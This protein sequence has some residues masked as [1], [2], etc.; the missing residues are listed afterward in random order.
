MIKKIICLVLLLQFVFSNTDVAFAAYTYNMPNDMKITKEAL[1]ELES[2]LGNDY[3]AYKYSIKNNGDKTYKLEIT[4]QDPKKLYK[5][6]AAN[7]R[8]DM[9]HRAIPFSATVAVAMPVTVATITAVSIAIPPI[10]ILGLA[11]SD[12]ELKDIG[13]GLF[14]YVYATTVLPVKSTVMLPYDTV[15]NIKETKKARK[16]FR[17]YE[18]Y[19]IDKNKPIKVKS[20]E[21]FEFYAFVDK[22]TDDIYFKIYYEIASKENIYHYFRY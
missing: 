16:E 3:K 7:F 10:G 9:F 11:T 4:V 13:Q 5:E 12:L 19:L 2:F 8:K 1:D 6:S 21:T 18:K 22:E 14:Q 15:R 17:K 20:G